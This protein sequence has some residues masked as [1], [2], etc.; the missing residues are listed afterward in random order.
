MRLTARG[1]KVL[2]RTI[3]AVKVTVAMTGLLLLIG[4]AGWMEGL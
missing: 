1:E 2:L 3:G 4:A